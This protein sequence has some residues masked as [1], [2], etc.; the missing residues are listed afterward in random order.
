[1]TRNDDQE[2]AVVIASMNLWSN[3]VQAWW[4]ITFFAADLAP[5]FHRGWI[6]TIVA[7]V[8]TVLVA[9][10]T[11]HLDYRERR[12][13]SL[14][15]APESTAGPQ[16]PEDTEEGASLEEKRPAPPSSNEA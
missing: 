12:Q 3:V 14:A 5:R 1:M 11:R 8:V 16:R 9:L 2:R 13:G 6:A 10:V 7:A 15:F 4:S